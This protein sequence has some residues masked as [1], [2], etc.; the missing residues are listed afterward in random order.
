MK[1]LLLFIIIV[2]KSSAKRTY[3]VKTGGDKYNELTPASKNDD[4]TELSFLN[5]FSRK[6]LRVSGKRKNSPGKYRKKPTYVKKSVEQRFWKP[7]GRKPS[8]TTQMDDKTKQDNDG[9]KEEYSDEVEKDDQSKST[10]SAAT[11]TTT[12]TTTT[13][14]AITP[15]DDIT[16]IETTEGN[17]RRD[18]ESTTE[19]LEPADTTT[20]E[21]TEEKYGRNEIKTKIGE[22]AN[23]QCS[24]QKPFDTCTFTHTTTGKSFNIQAGDSYEGD[25]IKC[26]CEVE[27]VDP[28]KVCGMHFTE[29]EEDDAG[30]W[31]CEIGRNGESETTTINLSVPG[32]MIDIANKDPSGYILQEPLTIKRNHLLKTI[33]MGQEYAVSFELFINSYSTSQWQSILH[34]THNLDSQSYGDRN[35]AVWMTGKGEFHIAQ[36]RSGNSLDYV[37][38]KIKYPLK[39]WIKFEITQTLVEKKQCLFEKKVKSEKKQ[40]LFEKKIM[41]EVKIDG[42]SMFKDYNLTPQMFKK[43]KVYAGDPWY[44]P[45]DGKI[46]NLWVK[47]CNRN[48]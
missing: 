4:Y 3:L 7:S 33:P 44:Q 24:S 12:T 34:F 27:N 20:I 28:K 48:L 16:T 30:E 19:A 5:Q 26:L 15:E 40:C 9:S 11:T 10:T 38:P 31:R 42:K 2:V 37:Q 13:T 47:S 29:V 35:P 21:T 45:L 36:A 14:E 46:K 25:R 32:C 17:H 22:K 1:Y 43:M 8:G 23:L 18:E 39:K 41:Y 6:N